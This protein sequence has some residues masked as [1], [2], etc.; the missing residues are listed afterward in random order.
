MIIRAKNIGEQIQPLEPIPFHD[1]DV[2]TIRIE[3]GI[4]SGSG[5]RGNPCLRRY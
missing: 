1:G 5:I 4:Q 2:I 3:P